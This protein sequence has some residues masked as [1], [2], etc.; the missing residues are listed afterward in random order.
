MRKWVLISIKYCI[1]SIRLVWSCK[2]ISV[3]NTVLLPESFV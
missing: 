3:S 1:N 2:V